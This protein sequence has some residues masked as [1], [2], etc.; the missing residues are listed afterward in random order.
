MV[1]AVLIAASLLKTG[2]LTLEGWMAFYMFMPKIGAMLRQLSNT[3]ITAKGVQG[4]AQRLEKNMDVPREELSAGDSVT[5]GAI[6]FKNV[7]FSYGEDKAL[8]NVSFT[9]PAGKVTAP[10]GLSGSGKSTILNLIERL[11]TPESGSITLNGKDVTPL[12]LQDYRRTTAYV[13]QDAGVFSGSYR[14]VLT[15]GIG[16]A[17]TERDLIRVSKLAGIYDFIAAQPEGF[18]SIIAPWGATLSGGRRQRLVIPLSVIVDILFG[19]AKHALGQKTQTALSDT[20]YYLIERTRNLPLIKVSS[21]SAAE[22]QRGK[23]AFDTQC[24]MEIRAGYL[25]VIYQAIDTALS[26]AGILLT[27]IAGCIPC[28]SGAYD[29]RRRHCLLHHLQLRHPVLFQSD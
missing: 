23:V 9:A 12:D 27:F 10:V 3:W 26:V 11:F 24:K 29:H 21:M 16:K 14:E 15:Y 7:T 4:Y 5:P 19:K 28:Q 2:E 1:A 20:T 18:D 17:V 22:N 8:E 25:S 6:T 13:P